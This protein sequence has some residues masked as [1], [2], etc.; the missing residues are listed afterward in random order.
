MAFGFDVSRADIAGVL[1]VII[2]G[3]YAFL[4]SFS[5]FRICKMRLAFKE[6]Y[7]KFEKKREKDTNRISKMG[8]R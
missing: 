7:K 2:G 3:F 1:M 6:D 8:P 4:F 5:L